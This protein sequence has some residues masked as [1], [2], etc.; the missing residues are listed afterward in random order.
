MDIV[1]KLRTPDNKLK[2]LNDKC[3]QRI[4]SGQV[5]TN[6][7]NVIKE[8]I[9]NAIDANSSNIEVTCPFKSIQINHMIQIRSDYMRVVTI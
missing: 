8:L 7:V 9:E 2:S 5:I 4:G 3:Q 6:L 1:S